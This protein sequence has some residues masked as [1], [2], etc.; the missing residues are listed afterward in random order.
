MCLHT[1]N[2]MRKASLLIFSFLIIELI[3]CKVSNLQNKTLVFGSTSFK[4]N[5]VDYRN[6]KNYFIELINDTV[7]YT[8]YPDSS[9]LYIFE[10]TIYADSSRKKVTGIKIDTSYEDVIYD[11]YYP[12]LPRKKND[13]IYFIYRDPISKNSKEKRWY[14]LFPN[15]TTLQ[16]S[17]FT[18]TLDGLNCYGRCFYTGRDNL[19]NLMGRK[20]NTYI[21]EENY[22]KQSEDSKCQIVITYL[23]K[24][25]LIPIIRKYYSLDETC[26]K[27]SGESLEISLTGILPLTSREKAT[28]R[29]AY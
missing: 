4:Y 27:Y 16:C 25:M 23:D 29:I 18:I 15:D 8:G 28:W 14:S 10:D 19:L 1:N 24:E 6:K 22:R 11:K 5:K 3:G 12:F 13:S 17:P 2:F 26:S 9:Q 20:F 21:F 7:Y